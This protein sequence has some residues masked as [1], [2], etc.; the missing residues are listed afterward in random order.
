MKKGFLRTFIVLVFC[1]V[2]SFSFSVTHS[3]AQELPDFEEGSGNEASGALL[4]PIDGS[5]DTTQVESSSGIVDSTLDF[6]RNIPFYGNILQTFEGAAEGAGG[7]YTESGGSLGATAGGAASGATNAAIGSIPGAE[8]AQG[9]IDFAKDPGASIQKVL[10]NMIS[11]AGVAVWAFF[12]LILGL[13]GQV[14]DFVLRYTVTSQTLFNSIRTP[15][16][17]AW[18]ILRDIANIAIVFSLLYLAIKTILNG[19]GFADTKTLAGVLVAAVLINFSLFFT[20]LAFNTSNFVAQRIAEQIQFDGGGTVSENIA[21]LSGV[22]GTIDVLWN[23]QYGSQGSTLQNVDE[24]IS[25][26]YSDLRAGFLAGLTTLILIVI[27]LVAALLLMYRFFV[28]TILM[29]SSPFGLISG[30]IPW[31]KGAGN[32]WWGELKKQFIFLPVFMLTLY[33]SLLFVGTISNSVRGATDLATYVYYFILTCGFLVL[34]LIVPLK[35]AEGSKGSLSSVTNW[36]VS[37]IRNTAKR[38]AQFGGR[39][40]AGGSARTARLVLG[41]GVGASVAGNKTL[42]AKAQGTGVGAFLARQAIQK[43]DSLKNKTYDIRNTDYGKKLGLGNGIESW[44]KAVETK[45]KALNDRAEKEKKLYGFNDIKAD[46]SA[47]NRAEKVRDQ[48]QK[49]HDKAKAVY[50]TTPTAANKKAYE[51]AEKELSRTQIEVG[52]AKNPG[53]EKY[54]KNVADRRRNLQWM[55]N[56]PVMRNW[57]DRIVMVMNHTMVRNTAYTEIKKDLYKK[58]KTDGTAKKKKKKGGGGSGSGSASSGSS[59]TSSSGGGS[60]SGSTGT[61]TGGSTP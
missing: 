29:I 1:F 13:V 25:Q 39:V 56:V 54:Q 5:S 30:F 57:N 4:P 53:A 10:L 41:K 27:L 32:Q 26:A 42:Q 55:E 51:D 16:N 17:I 22:K 49:D 46:L 9:I 28:F 45:K 60:A 61:F 38:S 37:K 19:N 23:K 7:A 43:G 52:K 12:G 44:S 8:T 21:K 18:T 58:Y 14:F 24:E 59:S 6:F 31:F 35:V 11:A 50:I 47:V 40:A 2:L 3:F 33:V 36:G 48:A 15:I 34:I 20:T